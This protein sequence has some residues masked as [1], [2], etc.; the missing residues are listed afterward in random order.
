MPPISFNESHEA[1]SGYYPPSAPEV[2][3]S[4]P[5]TDQLLARAMASGR[6]AQRLGY[7][8]DQAGG[9][10]C[11]QCQ[12]TAPTATKGGRCQHRPSPVERA[13]R[14]DWQRTADQTRL[15]QEAKAH[16]QAG[17]SALVVD[18]RRETEVMSIKAELLAL[19]DNL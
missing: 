8:Y 13:Q 14:A 4:A 3:A 2:K 11:L 10:V 1:L 15:L 9:N 7:G 19:F 6:E 12:V 16:G 17:P 5:G 18:W